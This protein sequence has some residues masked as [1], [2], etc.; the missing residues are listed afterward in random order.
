MGADHRSG[1]IEPL[2]E[3]IFTEP[4]KTKPVFQRQPAIDYCCRKLNDKRKIALWIFYTRNYLLLWLTFATF[5]LYARLPLMAEPCDMAC[6]W[7]LLK[8]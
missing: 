3:L 2:N 6:Q 5:I 8:T 1:G 7:W 4:G